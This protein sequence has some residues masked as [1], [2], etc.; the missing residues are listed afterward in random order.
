MHYMHARNEVRWRRCLS[1]R[2]QRSSDLRFRGC[3]AATESYDIEAE[4]ERTRIAVEEIYLL[5]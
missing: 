5:T 4:A 1:D 3:A 2:V